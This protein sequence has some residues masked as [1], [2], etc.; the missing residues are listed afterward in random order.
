VVG[1]G[2]SGGAQR[3]CIDMTAKGN[4][5][6]VACVWAHLAACDGQGPVAG[7][8]KINQAEHRKVAI[9]CVD[10]GLCSLDEDRLPTGGAN[11]VLQANSEKQVLDQADNR[12]I[13]RSRCRQTWCGD[14]HGGTSFVTFDYF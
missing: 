10:K 3:G 1:A 4:N 13:R 14:C 6:N 12:G 7:G 8:A 9:Q 11:N 2:L 5:G